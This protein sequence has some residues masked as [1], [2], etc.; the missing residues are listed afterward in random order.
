MKVSHGYFAQFY[1]V[2]VLSSLFWAV[3]V[4]SRGAALQAVATR[5]HPDRLQNAMSLNQVLL[6]WT[7]MLVQGT[8]RLVECLALSKPSSS[9][10]WLGHWLIGIAFYV[11]VSVAIWIEGAGTYGAFGFQERGS[12]R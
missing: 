12:R 2:S 1:I 9:Q 11:A 6:C 7:L 5:I 4:L 10:M 3:Q 8:R